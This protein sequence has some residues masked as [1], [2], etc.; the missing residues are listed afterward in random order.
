MFTIKAT[1]IHGPYATDKWQGVFE[2][3]SE[4]LLED[5]HALIQSTLNFDDD[6]LYEFF[7]A[8]TESSRAR[9]S[10]DDEN[11]GLYDTSIDSLFPLPDKKNL[12]YLFDYGDHWLF[13]ITKATKTAREPSRDE[14]YPR[15]IH[16][17]GTRPP[18]YPSDDE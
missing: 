14:E 7:I 9:L 17:S 18:Q 4:S 11:G 13:K 10:F 15:L 12:Y 8:R 16:E 6:H 1:L 2:I 3:E 5:I